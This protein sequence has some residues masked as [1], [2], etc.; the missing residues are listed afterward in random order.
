MM[1]CLKKFDDKNSLAELS[2]KLDSGT[3]WFVFWKVSLHLTKMR[4]RQ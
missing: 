4:I 1:T 2:S 3:D